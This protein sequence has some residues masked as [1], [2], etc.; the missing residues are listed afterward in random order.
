MRLTDDKLNLLLGEVETMPTLTVPYQEDENDIETFRPMVTES[1]YKA[2][3]VVKGAKLS[4][5]FYDTISLLMNKVAD[6]HTLKPIHELK[7]G[8][9]G[10]AM[11]LIEWAKEKGVVYDIPSFSTARERIKSR[12][13]DFNPACPVEILIKYRQDI[14]VASSALDSFREALFDSYER[15]GGQVLLD[16]G[17]V[18]TDWLLRKVGA[19]KDLVD[20]AAKLEAYKDSITSK[21]AT[22]AERFGVNGESFAPAV[23]VANLYILNI[24]EQETRRKQYYSTILDRLCEEHIR[25]HGYAPHPETVEQFSVKA[26]ELMS[27]YSDRGFSS[28][29]GLFPLGFIQ[30]LQWIGT[31][32][33]KTVARKQEYVN[34]FL[35]NGSRLTEEQKDAF[36][37]LSGR[38]MLF[39]DGQV[40]GLFV[41]S[42]DQVRLDERF[43]T[44]KR[45]DLV[46]VPEEVVDEMM[47]NQFKRGAKLWVGGTQAGIV[48]HTK[49]YDSGVSVFLKNFKSF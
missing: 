34:V 8:L 16:K 11:Q 4:G 19:D 27:E 17:K 5:S 1:L 18:S 31:G 37:N 39:K 49:V 21:Y 6:S 14:Q 15:D 35:T 23:L 26:R 33:V 24:K 2:K 42:E 10:E 38:L 7:H 45:K 22:F 28:I 40:N 13:G 29:Q 3:G 9:N 36:R 20:R 44:P 48:M 12:G 47:D 32:H 46:G 30:F 43:I 25:S 41:S